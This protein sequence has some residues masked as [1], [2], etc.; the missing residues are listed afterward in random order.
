MTTQKQ[1][2]L[3]WRVAATQPGT[4]GTCNGISTT[5]LWLLGPGKGSREDSTCPKPCCPQL[6]VSCLV[7]DLPALS[8]CPRQPGHQ[9]WMP[10]GYLGVARDDKNERENAF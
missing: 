10:L 2:L 3:G 1:V 7:Q 9:L 6:T 4:A 8:V 5:S